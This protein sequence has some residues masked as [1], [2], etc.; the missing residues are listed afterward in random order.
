[1][2][3]LAV[4]EDDWARADTLLRRKFPKG[5]PFD[6]RV[7][8]AAM[9]KDTASLRQLRLE[10]QKTAGDKGRKRDRAPEGRLPSGDLS[11]G[12]RLGRAVHPIQHPV[13]ASGPSA[14]LGTPGPGLAR[15]RRR[16][17]E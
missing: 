3:D 12:P 8:F 5:L 4:R 17:V 9:R 11:R 15:C 7:V 14:D 2:A 10:G 1:M 6:V 16:T 13:L